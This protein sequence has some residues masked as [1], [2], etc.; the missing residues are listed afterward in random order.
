M[1]ISRI[2]YYS[3]LLRIAVYAL[4]LLAFGTSAYVRFG[5][6]WLTGTQSVEA[7]D[8]LIFLLV[9][10]FVWI[11]AANHY[12][13]S[14]VTNLFW[15]HTGIRA[16]FVA[17]C[18]T[19]LL[20]TVLLVFAKQLVISRF[21]V[22]L[23]ITLLFVSMVGTRLLFR[24]FSTFSKLPRKD[25]KIL[26]VGSDQYARRAVKLLNRVP[27]VRFKVQGYLR[28]PNQPVM[29]HDAPVIGV[30]DHAQIEALDFD[31]VVVAAHAERYLHASKFVDRLQ[32][33]GKPVRAILDLGPRLS[34]HEKLFQ[35]GRLQ[36]MS[37]A[38]FP[39]ESFAYTV[40]KRAFDLAFAVLAIILLSPIML[41]IALLVKLSSPGPILFKQE[42]IGR[43]G[44]FFVLL[45]FRTMRRSSKAEE[46]TTWTTQG[47]ARCTPIGTI[48]RKLS[49]DE[50]PQFW[51]VVRGEMSL[52]GPRPERPHFAAQFRAS[53]HRYHTRHCCQV[54]ITGWAQV[55]GLRGDTSISDRLQHDL[56][57]I[58]NWSLGLDLQI[59]A[60]TIFTVLRDRNGY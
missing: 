22:L 45:K 50:L 25:E 37:L 35:V 1:V 18:V 52:V 48:L 51:N 56:Y 20:Q 27:F 28:L 5:S 7:Q 42:R 47:D 31:E 41:G 57:Y 58:R 8:Y 14:S 24:L 39:V 26:V 33:L 23:S 9:T 12:K 30:D 32:E 46:D 43:H 49:L 6:V 10:E 19:F 13:L 3:V 38:I 40:L 21:F 53:L 11:L 34:L 36:V 15:E 44:R 59:I 29:V 55:N 54:G 60:R 16:A 2:Y 17:C 4:P